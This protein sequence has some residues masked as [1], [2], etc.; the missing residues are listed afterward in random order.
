MNKLMK[1][2][3]ALVGLALTSVPAHAAGAM[4]DG[5]GITATTNNLNPGASFSV[6]G[7]VSGL[8]LNGSG[9]HGTGNG[10]EWYTSNGADKPNIYI[11]F[12]LGAA[13]VLDSMHVWNATQFV[14]YGIAQLDIYVSTVAVPSDAISSDWTLIGENKSFAA[15]GSPNVGF[16]LK[17]QTGI[18]LPTT[19]VRHVRFEADT[20]I[21]AGNYVGLAE[22]QFF[23]SDAVPEPSA[24][25]LP[26]SSASALLGLGG[27][28]LILRK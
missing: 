8:G 6:E 5:S 15:A 14:D 3:A 2:I 24:T 21:G 16:D 10:F 12:D 17:T 26:V 18:T 7:T 19:A 11:S 27:V 23:T 28:T 20:T 13:Y 22:V 1:T 9:E 4:I 25:A